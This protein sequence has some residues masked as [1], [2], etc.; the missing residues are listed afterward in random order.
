M[1]WFSKRDPQDLQSGEICGSKMS[2][3]F[4]TNG[5][6]AMMDRPLVPMNQGCAH[7]VPV[8]IAF[9][10]QTSE[11]NRQTNELTN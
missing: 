10:T 9:L 3:L 5:A 8:L 11:K 7:A 1:G 6:K 4:C 2:L